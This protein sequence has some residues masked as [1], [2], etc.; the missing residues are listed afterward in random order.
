MRL[1]FPVIFAALLICTHAAFASGGF[2]CSINDKATNF[3]A[4]A[5][6]SRGLGEQ[7][8]NFKAELE[9]RV[10]G[11]PDDLRKLDLSEH[12]TQKWYY[13]RDLKLR[14]YR[15]RENEK[16]HGYVEI[17]IQAR[18]TKS[19]DDSD[20]RGSYVLTVYDVPANGGSEGKTITRRGRVTCS[21]E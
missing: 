12:L 9:V 11:T 4:M 20:Y 6:V 8:I 5:A 17:V 13:D 7:I 15:E 1:I 2:S 10:P 18:R 14:L 3:E 21:G 19:D 16:P